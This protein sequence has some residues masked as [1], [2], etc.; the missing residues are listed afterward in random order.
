M[1]GNPVKP[2]WLVGD[3]LNLRI[4]LSGVGGAIGHLLAVNVL[5][6][7]SQLASNTENRGGL[8]RG[9]NLREPHTNN[10]LSGYRPLSR[11][12]LNNLAGK[13]LIEQARLRDSSLA[14]LRN[15]LEHLD[16]DSRVLI[17]RQVGNCELESGL[18]GDVGLGH[19]CYLLVARG[20]WLF[21]SPLLTITIRS[22]KGFVNENFKMCRNCEGRRI[23]LK[24][25]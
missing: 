14:G 15:L 1:T 17:L 6:G 19:F 10:I 13:A 22:L 7:D 24:V 16:E 25:N 3:L 12:L 21:R 23:L 4:I 2:L 5:G 11:E 9:R 18:A 20:D 8:L